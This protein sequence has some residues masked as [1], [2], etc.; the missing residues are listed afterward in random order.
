MQKILLAYS[1]GARSSAAIAWL[2]QRYNA[3]VVALTLDIGQGG[4]LEAVRDGALAL[5]A[6]R[7]HVLDVRDEFARHF[8][9]PA[10]KA[11]GLYDDRQSRA[12][13]L[14]RPLIAQ[15][16]VEVSAIEQTTTVAHASAAE[17]PQIGAAIQALNPL[18]EVV[19]LPADLPAP[20]GV[21]TEA[22]NRHAMSAKSPGECPDEPAFVEV[23]FSRGMPTAINA[24]AMPLVDL[25]GSLDIIAGANGV[26]RYGALE[27]PAAW[28]LHAA[29]KDL[30]SVTII[31][32]A[33]AFSET[34]S[35]QF[36][37]VIERGAWFS[38]LREA[39]E[40][41][42]DKIQNRVTGVV[43]LQLFKGDCKVVEHRA[44]APET[45]SATPVRKLTF[46]ATAKA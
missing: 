4:D 40:A 7:A 26:G 16:L 1:G 10:L 36:A 41:Y 14:S 28:V 45:A 2:S 32:E 21:W 30:Q 39:L 3:E 34:V 43:R 42:V 18:L 13:F 37:G 22:V 15:K 20:G 23:T 17:D 25:I 35:Q 9:I 33:A 19:A 29:H 12:S 6:I 31:D 24:V 11:D 27:S 46:T 8:L 38:P 5:G 44:S